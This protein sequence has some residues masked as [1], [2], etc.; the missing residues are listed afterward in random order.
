MV[1]FEYAAVTIFEGKDFLKTR[2]RNVTSEES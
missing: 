1:L 2:S